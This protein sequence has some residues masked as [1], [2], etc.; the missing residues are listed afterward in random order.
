MP[1]LAQLSRLVDLF[2]GLET[3]IADATDSS[4]K[5]KKAKISV[6]SQTENQIEVSLPY[7]SLTSK[8][9]VFLTLSYIKVMEVPFIFNVIFRYVSWVSLKWLQL[10]WCAFLW[11]STIVAC[12]FKF[13][14]EIRDCII[15]CLRYSVL[16][17]LNLSIPCFLWFVVY[18]EVTSDCVEIVHA[19]LTSLTCQLRVDVIGEETDRVFGQ[20]LTNLA[21]TAPPIP[22]FRRQKGG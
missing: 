22:G 7:I 16:D 9:A 14:D 5:L 13:L 21:R 18:I 17:V 4:I 12:K 3:S 6:E 15:N 20:V 1:W 11:L 10:Y 19:I 2:T 8:V